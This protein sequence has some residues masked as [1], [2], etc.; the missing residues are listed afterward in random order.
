MIPQ[1]NPTQPTRFRNV[2]IPGDTNGTGFWRFLAPVYCMNC[3]PSQAG[4][5]NE[6]IHVPPGDPQ[7][8]MDVNMV[9]VQRMTTPGQLNFIRF[10]SSIRQVNGMTIVYNIDDCM[11]PDEIP[12]CNRGRDHYAREEVQKSIREMLHLCDFVLVTTSRIKQ[13]YVEKYGVEEH[14]VMCIPNLLPKWW[15]GGKFDLQKKLDGFK[16]RKKSK[17]RVGVVSSAS[18]W[19]CDKRRDADGEVIRD[20][21]DQIADCVRSTCNSVEWSIVGHMPWQI[22][23]LCK[24]GKV[25]THAPSAILAY[26]ELLRSLDFDCIVVPCDPQSVFNQCKANIKWLEACALGVPVLC[27]DVPFA[28]SPYVPDRQRFKTQ[29]Q[30]KEMILDLARASEKKF[31]D[32]VQRQHDFLGRS[33]E[34]AGVKI[35]SWWLEDNL[36]IWV[37]IC[38]I[39]QKLTLQKMEIMKRQREM[40]KPTEVIWE[41]ADKTCQIVK[42]VEDRQVSAR[43]TRMTQDDPEPN[44]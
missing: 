12:M 26:P 34:E 39:P 16:T 44:S 35:K 22:E 28:Y 23:D 29:D 32:I 4:I 17:I 42:E 27:Q 21:F 2:F 24:Q 8:W 1:N 13:Y 37:K 11:H 15:I 36:D 30:L 7:W 41:N 5:V 25:K 40:M 14:K 19:N 31:Q 38:R 18:H 20:D 9:M 43:S 3:F 33:C 6:V 10:L